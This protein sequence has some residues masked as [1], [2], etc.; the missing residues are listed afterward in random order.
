[1]RDPPVPSLLLYK[2]DQGPERERNSPKVTQ[3]I[4]AG[5]GPFPLKDTKKTVNEK[6][7]WVGAQRRAGFSPSLA[8]TP[9]PNKSHAG[10]LLGHLSCPP[11]PLGFLPASSGGG[12]GEYFLRADCSFKDPPSLP[13]SPLDSWESWARTGGEGGG[14]GGSWEAAGPSCKAW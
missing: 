10:N 5:L 1:M 7:P 12:H 6:S 13:P 9:I 2:G 3:Q 4:K 14:L 11:P 8:P